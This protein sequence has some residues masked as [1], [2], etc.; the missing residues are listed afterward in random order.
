LTRNQRLTD[1][2]KGFSTY[3]KTSKT[4]SEAIQPLDSVP[5]TSNG[6]LMKSSQLNRRIRPDSEATITLAKES[7]DLLLAPSG[8][9]IQNLLISES[10]LAASAQ[11]KDTLRDA[12]IDTP[13][14]LRESLPLGIGSMLPSTPYAAELA[15]F[16]QKTSEEE[17]A[18]ALLAKVASLS[19]KP[20][21][22]LPDAKQGALNPSKV[23][24]G[25]DPEE[26]ALIV[27]EL[28][29]NLPKYGPLIRQLGGKVSD[30]CLWSCC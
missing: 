20:N 16:L 1:L 10:S 29:T 19:P 14:K 5:S 2:S 25:V 15:M 6:A 27:R 9:L 21:F 13:R 30:V 18:Q 12:I 7:A 23:L 4:I 8:N 24:E 28:R 22:L 17:K 26:V 11:V 3:T